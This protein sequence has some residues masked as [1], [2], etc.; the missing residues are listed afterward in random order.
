MGNRRWVPPTLSNDTILKALR[1]ISKLEPTVTEIA[2][3]NNR[4]F[5]IFIDNPST[6]PHYIKLN[7]KNKSINILIATLA[8]DK[9]AR[10]VDRHKTELIIAK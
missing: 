6:I 7:F 4:S 8:D 9:L 5:T 10:H 1:K 2:F 3:T